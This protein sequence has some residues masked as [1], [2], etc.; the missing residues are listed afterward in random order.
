[1]AT[2]TTIAVLPL[3]TVPLLAQQ[4]SYRFP[5]NDTL[6]YREVTE[7]RIELRTQQGTVTLTPRHDAIIALVTDRGDTVMAW[8]EALTL[9]SVGPQGEWRPSTNAALNLP[10]RLVVTRGGQ[11]TTVSLPSF[12]P[13]IASRTDLTRQF[14]D[15]FISLPLSGLRPQATWADTLESTR[16][17]SPGD[18]YHSRHVRRYRALRDTVLAGGLGAV[19]IAFE[20]EITVRSSSPMPNAPVT[21]HTRLEGREEGTAVFAP[22]SARL[23]WRVRRGRLEGEQVLRGE[24]REMTVPMSYEYSSSLD[25]LR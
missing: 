12:P 5:P 19:V 11:V 24:G 14:E 15:F 20:Q 10:F 18:T 25:A 21:I 4:A 2:L 16:A 7:S 6:K 17:T 9:S 22:A 3:L 1:M 23:L 8:Y 13:E